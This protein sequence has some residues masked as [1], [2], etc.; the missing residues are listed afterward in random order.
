MTVDAIVHPPASAGHPAV[1]AAV[2]DL[3]AA[4]D[5]GKLTAERDR[6]MVL[7]AADYAIAAHEGQVRKSGE[8]F[9][10]H[11]ITVAGILSRMNM[12]AETVVAGLLH[13]VVED[14]T[15]ALEDIEKAFTERV[16][17]L[18]DGVT[19]LGRLAWTGAE[20]RESREK[21]QQAESLRKM[22]LAMID[23]IGVVI[24]KLADRM[25]NMRTLDSMTR[26][27]QLRIAQQTLEIYAP[28]ANRLGIWQ[29]KS[30]L[31]DLSF[32]YLRPAD[33]QHIT[34]ELEKR[35]ADQ[36]AY[37]ERAKVALRDVLARNSVQGTVS[38]RRKHIYSIYRK[39]Q[40]K[41][42][43]IDE[44]YDVVGLRIIVEDRKD[45]YAAL[46]ALHTEWRP[47][48][49][50]FDDYI[51]NPKE[52]S[53]QSLHTALIGP[54]GHYLEVQIRTWEMHQ[55]A[56][57][58]IAAHWRYK[59]GTKGNAA[60]E[61]KIA[62]LRQLMD[63]RDEVADAEEFVES[64]K[65]DVFKE[66][67]YCFTPAGD[68]LEMPAGA[69]PV[70]FA[71]R[72]HTDVGN[73][74]VGAMIGDVHVGLDYKL[75]NGEV[76]R[77]ITSHQRMGPSRD[78][79]L[80]DNRFVT[81]AN[82]REKIRQWFRRRDRDEN[83]KDGRQ[84]LERELKRLGV[85]PKFE[86]IARQFPNYAKVDDFLAAIG[87]GGVSTQS[88][89]QRLSETSVKDTITHPIGLRAPSSPPRRRVAG[90]GDLLTS[91]AQCCNPVNGDEIIG[92]VTRGR[93]ITVHR[94]NC[95]NIASITER[96]RLMP[97]AWNSAPVESFVAPIRVQ[98]WDRVGLLKD[99]STLFADE[100]LNILSVQTLTKDDRTV[101]IQITTEV[102]DVAQ[103]S[104]ILRR[105]EGIAD[106][107]WARRDT[108]GGA[109]Q[110]AR[111]EA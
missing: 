31:E 54:E 91:L 3:R 102:T 28:L 81:T 35:G 20:D 95:P 68:I 97:I 52:S 94:A 37:V 63:W 110:A 34:S 39:M 106:V 25:H 69:T 88:I 55:V 78:W 74:C 109:Q 57:F 90:V 70:D 4:L 2:E 24:V 100:D 96:E 107:A 62:W 64:L 19:K 105:L 21:R 1:V 17:R 8:P 23:D 22:F 71:Y 50:E 82:A 46:G 76:V 27:K 42:R 87:Y 60:L 59:E 45:C 11:P 99:I 47:V 80:P 30:E 33:Y 104:H 101:D 13:D 12:D 15:T 44:I 18:V 86:E 83:I 79:L 58:G 10:T 56:E 85:E 98:A 16:A 93:G 7:R 72:I 36:D 9:V 6:D 32:R 5:E 67:I 103:L 41:N 40:Q 51:A 53:Y 73:R 89:V 92:Y 61:A 111:I 14:S 108:S 49:S 38:G 26:E 84:I 77:V 66:M 29:M 65:S 75:R 43:S 48:P